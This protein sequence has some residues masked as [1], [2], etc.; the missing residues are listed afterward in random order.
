[1]ALFNGPGH[2]I[3]TPDI[4]TIIFSGRFQ[5]NGTSTPD[6]LVGDFVT[7]V[8]RSDTGDFLLTFDK[9]IAQIHYIHAT[10]YED[11]DI[12]ANVDGIT[13]ME[14]SGAAT[15]TIHTRTGGS[16]ADPTDDS[17]VGF[18]VVGKQTSRTR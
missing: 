18:V 15:A 17:Y 4:R 9:T 10:V 13:A 6:N 11:A 12:I 3:I 8:A 16:A 7:S 1:M 14:G 5:I 2:G